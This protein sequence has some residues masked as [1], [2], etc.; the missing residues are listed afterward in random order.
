MQVI[1][2]PKQTPRFPQMQS[3]RLAQPQTLYHMYACSDWAELFDIP[4]CSY[5]LL[6]YVPNSNAHYHTALSER[7][8]TR[9]H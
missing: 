7:S 8:T 2:G 5:D 9:P 4:P 1:S 3:D 6:F